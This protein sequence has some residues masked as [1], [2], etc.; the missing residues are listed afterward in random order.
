[1]AKDE[2]TTMRGCLAFLKKSTGML[3]G[4][5]GGWDLTHIG[6]AAVRG[7]ENSS[8]VLSFKRVN[9][10]LRERTDFP[11][12]CKRI[13]SFLEG[14]QSFKTEGE[15]D[16]YALLPAFWR[17]RPCPCKDSVLPFYR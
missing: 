2:K 8:W 5:L 7:L 16:V 6:L 14:G 1:M 3:S 13:G 17:V 11:T 4:N 15:L 12:W 10:N 9:L